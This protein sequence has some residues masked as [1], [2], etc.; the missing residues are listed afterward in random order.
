MNLRTFKNPFKSPFK[1]L[2]ELKARIKVVWN[3]VANDRATIRKALKE[4]VSRLQAVGIKN[5]DSIK[6]LFGQVLAEYFSSVLWL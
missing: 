4:F 2:G 1:N 5:G 6:T 3:D